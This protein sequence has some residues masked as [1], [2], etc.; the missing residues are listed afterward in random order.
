MFICW[1]PVDTRCSWVCT[2]KWRHLL[3]EKA[4]GKDVSE[5]ALYWLCVDWTLI[6]CQSGTSWSPWHTLP[7]KS[8]IPVSNAD[9]I[10]MSRD[11]NCYIEVCFQLQYLRLLCSLASC[12]PVPHL[13]LIWE[14]ASGHRVYRACHKKEPLGKI[15]YLWN[16]SKFFR[17][18][19]SAYRGGFRPHI[20]QNS[21]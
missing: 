10:L 3:A 7:C 17:Q 12:E 1:A 2:I 5:S 11:T 18:L 8:K 14:A 9:L 4:A 19:Y 13:S 15:R 6:C 21:S 16:G 20:L